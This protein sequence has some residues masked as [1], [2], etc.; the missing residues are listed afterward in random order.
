M[1]RIARM[2]K[3]FRLLRILKLRKLIHTFYDRFL[4]YVEWVQL[5]LQIFQNIGMV[6]LLTHQ[7]GCVWYGSSVHLI[8]SQD[9]TWVEYYLVGKEG[10][11]TVEAFD[12]SLKYHYFTAVHWAI[13][14]VSG[15]TDIMPKNWQERALNIFV[16]S[17][18]LIVFSSFVS[19]MTVAVTRLRNLHAAEEK[20]FAVLRK[21]FREN[22]IP[23][24]L[25]MGIYAFV[26]EKQTVQSQNMSE[27]EVD[28]LGMLPKGLYSQL[29]RVKQE[30]RLRQ[31]PVFRQLH[32][33]EPAN[34]LMALI[35]TEACSEKIFGPGEKV[36]AV[37]DV[38]R[39]MYFLMRGDFELREYRQNDVESFAIS[40]PKADA[41]DRGVPGNVVSP[42]V[43]WSSIARPVYT[44]AWLA[45]FSMFQRRSHDTMLIAGTYCE[46]LHVSR[47]S[48][49]ILVQQFP[50][51]Y[52]NLQDANRSRHAHAVF[53][54]G[55]ESEVGDWIRPRSRYLYNDGSREKD[56]VDS[57]TVTDT[58][59]VRRRSK[60]AKTLP[61]QGPGAF[62]SV[63]AAL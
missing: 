16:L 9:M 44:V 41:G 56:A 19:S 8:G 63:M 18:T 36:Y 55:S 32:S 29:I 15:N 42:K 26:E 21:Y 25:A 28:L 17:L 12:L 51:L 10:E 7:M 60:P 49:S 3:V 48:F 34:D 40:S 47:Q 54:M 6:L 35:S 58:T 59:D 1:M 5:L 45:E 38:S 13:A 20:P 52:A 22:K 50:V 4:G 30:P 2:I 53:L 23:Y 24:D 46:V 31:Y 11:S 62:T 61:A 37:D 43:A 39:G 33:S 57:D 14:Q 27:R